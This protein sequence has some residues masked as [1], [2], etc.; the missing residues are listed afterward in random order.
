M[1]ALTAADLATWLSEAVARAGVPSASLAVL[2]GDE[3][4]VAQA[5]VLSVATGFPVSADSVF[6]VGSTTKV[7]TAA[8]LLQLVDEGRLSLDTPVGDV[9]AEFHNS[10]REVAAATV[11]QLL[12]HT[13]GLAGNYFADFGPGP[14]SISKYVH[15]LAR[16]EPIHPAG[17]F[18]SYSNGGYV[19]AGRIAEVLTGATFAELVA[20]RIARRLDLAS[21][22]TSVEDVDPA[23]LAAGH[24][25]DHNGV[26]QLAERQI[27]AWSSTPAGSQMMATAADLARFGRAAMGAGAPALVSE[28][29]SVLMTTSA[30]ELP[31]PYWGSRAQCLGWGLDVRGDATVLLHGGGTTGHTAMLIAVPEADVVVAL[32]T[33][34]AAGAGLLGDAERSLL[35]D[36]AGVGPPLATPSDPYPLSDVEAESLV[37]TYTDI[38]TTTTVIYS[39]SV[40][41]AQRQFHETPMSR[42]M[43]LPPAALRAVGPR[44]FTTGGGRPTLFIGR[45]PKDPTSPVTHMHQRVASRRTP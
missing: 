37:G 17:A 7:M 19:V 12:D 27:A 15:S 35:N 16:V 18:F 5:G 34:S 6:Q 43:E 8:I 4:V 40:V 28:R 45:D 14:A 1:S 13:S 30:V 23:E 24:E 41:T 20:E 29:S 33:N 25:P 22:T 21:L 38:W 32:L 10:P 42:A 31:C 2:H 44:L 11:R 39:D 36:I 3:L 26:N 9:L